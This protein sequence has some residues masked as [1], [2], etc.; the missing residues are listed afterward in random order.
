VESGL[1]TIGSFLLGKIR[2]KGRLDSPSRNIGHIQSVKTEATVYICCMKYDAIIFDLGGILVD[3]DYA[4]PGKRFRDLGIEG[5]SHIFFDGGEGE[6][7]YKYERGEVSTDAFFDVLRPFGKPGL[8]FE[9]M[10][11][12]WNAILVG[13]PTH[14]I[15]MLKALQKDYRLFLLSN[16]NELHLAAFRTMTKMNFPGVNFDELFEKAYYSNLLGKRKPEEGAF[17]AVLDRHSLIPE[18]VLYIDDSIQHIEAAARLGIKARW[19]KAPEEEVTEKI[20][21]WLRG[22]P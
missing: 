9:E 16:I 11:D 5:I 18:K 8:T 17:R 2:G 15:D 20:T 10:K 14:R 12:A 13:F 7:F 22:E 4:A 21:G 3:I 6:I 19:L 1:I